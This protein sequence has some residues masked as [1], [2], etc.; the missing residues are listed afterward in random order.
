MRVRQAHNFARGAICPVQLRPVLR[1]LRR[2]RALKEKI[3]V[4]R[5]EIL[6]GKITSYPVLASRYA[7]IA[8]SDL[9]YKNLLFIRERPPEKPL[10]RPFLNGNQA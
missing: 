6:R 8:T 2:F 1:R 9:P 3:A 7:F 4:V 5:G 10:Q